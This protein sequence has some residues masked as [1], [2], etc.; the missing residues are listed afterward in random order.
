MKLGKCLMLLCFLMESVSNELD[1]Y[2][3][4]FNWKFRENTS[5][6]CHIWPKMEF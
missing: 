6:Y 2:A 1:I 5:P 4:A 3:G